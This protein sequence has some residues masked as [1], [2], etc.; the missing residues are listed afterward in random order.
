MFGSVG[1]I[2]A[3]LVGMAAGGAEGAEDVSAWPLPFAIAPLTASPPVI[4]GKLAEPAWGSSPKLGP[5]V[6]LAGGPAKHETYAWVTRSKDTL[7]VGIRCAFPEGSTLALKQTKRD[8]EVWSD[9]SIEVFVDAGVSLRKQHVPGPQ[10][11]RG[12]NADITLIKRVLGWEPLIS[13]EQGLALTYAWIEDQVRARLQ[14]G[15]A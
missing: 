13:L 15:G 11:V 8:S 7:F 3:V 5:L 4:D 6:T 10:G 1:F 14:A 9:E 12:R 2:L